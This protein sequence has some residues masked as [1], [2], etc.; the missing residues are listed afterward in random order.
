MTNKER[1]EFF[2]KCLGKSFLAMNENTTFAERLQMINDLSFV[3]ESTN[4]ETIKKIVK[5]EKNIFI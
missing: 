1:N 2:M 3:H 4:Q 5:G